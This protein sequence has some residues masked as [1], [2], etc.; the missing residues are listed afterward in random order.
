MSHQMVDNRLR[1]ERL[2]ILGLEEKPA[3]RIVQRKAVRPS[4]SQVRGDHPKV[5]RPRFLGSSCGR[6]ARLNRSAGRLPQ[7]PEGQRLIERLSGWRLNALVKPFD[8]G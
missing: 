1:K 6:R 2:E 5:D 3:R 8:E 4:K 7:I